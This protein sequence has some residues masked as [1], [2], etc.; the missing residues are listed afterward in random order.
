MKFKE[1]QQS[2]FR[3]LIAS[4]LLGLFLMSNFGVNFIGHHHHHD[5]ESVD[6]KSIG[7]HHDCY[8]YG[9]Q[10]LLYTPLMQSDFITK[11]NLEEIESPFISYSGH[12]LSSEFSYSIS[13]RGPPALF[14]A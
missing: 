4:M 3:N 14:L 9:F 12:F 13:Q 6:T 1:R 10:G 8:V 11:I 7:H 5:S 2:R